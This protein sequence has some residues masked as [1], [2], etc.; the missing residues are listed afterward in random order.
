MYTESNIRSITKGLSWRLIATLT[1]TVI[2]Y[3]I[4]ER[5][6]LAI[7]AGA[8]E[9]VLKI[10]LYWAH[11][12][13]WV[14]VKW[15]KQKIKPFS[16]WITGLPFSSKT[17]VADDV[18]NKLTKT[19]TPIE[20]ID[21]KDIRKIVPSTGYSKADRSRHLLRVGYLINKLQHNSISTVSSFISPFASSRDEVANIVENHIIVYIK[22]DTK[23]CKERAIKAKAP[24]NIILDCDNYEEPKNATLTINIDEVGK[25]QASE[26]I[27]EYLKRNFDIY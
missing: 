25:E 14:K 3:I 6:D 26:E 24:Q 23:K 5:I 11:E 1:T 27:I 22:T 17:M 13:F 4:F 2:V 8:I 9:S 16:L 20:R 12:R 19:H 21:A 7:M 15:G 10:A 18:Y